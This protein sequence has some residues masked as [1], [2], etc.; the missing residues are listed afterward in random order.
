MLLTNFF[1]WAATTVRSSLKIE[2]LAER[3]I[4]TACALC[5]QLSFFAILNG[6]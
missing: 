2:L 6:V 4:T 3:G 5:L 1:R